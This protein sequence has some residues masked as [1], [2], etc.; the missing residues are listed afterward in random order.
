MTSKQFRSAFL[1]AVV[2][3]IPV[4]AQ[5]SPDTTSQS[6]PTAITSANLPE[7]ST[8]EQTPSFQVKVN[9]VEVRVVVRD[10]QGKAIGNLKQDD[11][12]LL[13]DKKPQTITRFS[14]ERNDAA[15]EST[16]PNAATPET[17]EKFRVMIFSNGSPGRGAWLTCS[18]T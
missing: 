2:A 5:S 18:T 12:V 3:S 4:F 11:F 13:D 1:F 8:Q 14:V 7:I 17:V 10:A 6:P 15:A 16:A 9:L